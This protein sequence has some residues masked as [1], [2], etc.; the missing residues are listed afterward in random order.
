MN[1]ETAIRR[2]HRRS[3][4]GL[5]EALQACAV[6]GV[7]EGRHR[8]WLAESLGLVW[9]ASTVHTDPTGTIDSV[10]QPTPSALS[11]ADASTKEEPKRL[12][13]LNPVG[14]EQMAF[15]K[16]FETQV[17]Q[18]RRAVEIK[19]ATFAASEERPALQP[20]LLE[21]WFQGIFTAV[22][23]TPV[24]S[25]EIDFREL[26]SSVF[27]GG[28]SA[29][30]PFKSKA[31]LVKG[32]HVLLDR[33]ES[34]QPFLRDQT[35][36]VARLRGLLGEAP[37]QHTW[38]EYDPLRPVESRLSW[39]TPMPRHFREQTPV[40]LVTDFGSGLD[41]STARSMEFD[42]WLPVL[43]L[44]RSSHCRIFALIACSPNFWPIE[45]SRFVDGS[46]LWDR[47]TSPQS[48][49]RLCRR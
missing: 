19:P 28:I 46:L 31:R 2:G 15:Q 32:V 6:L 8:Q 11:A 24:P 44:A 17:D 10:S 47:E 43:Q 37:V 45:L 40:L 4:V 13:L 14:Q 7:H 42:P 48:A 12:K 27:R 21:R 3:E 18:V 34:M 33:S 20:L 9:T 29:Q 41:P 22:L 5:A 16:L 23:A 39:H 38:F 26:E 1:P 35:E 36:L 30:L 49:A 25:G